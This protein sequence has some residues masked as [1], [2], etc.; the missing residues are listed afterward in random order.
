MKNAVFR[1]LLA[2]ERTEMMCS[3]KNGIPAPNIGSESDVWS[4]GN[5]VFDSTVL[6]PLEVCL[7][8][9]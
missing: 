3:L 2:K 6:N 1:T 8:S 7:N 9:A 4:T 5:E